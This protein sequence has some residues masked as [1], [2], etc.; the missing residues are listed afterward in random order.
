VKTPRFIRLLIPLLL[1]STPL[2]A[3]TF[4][5]SVASGDPGT[6]SVVLWTRVADPAAPPATD[7]PLTL[8]VA[9][10]PAMTTLVQTRTNL[11]ARA[12]NDFCIKVRVTG[13]NPRTRYWYRFTYGGTNRSPVGRT[14]TAALPTDPAP[15]RF[16]YLNCQ[17]YIGRHYN[18]LADLARREADTLDFVVH[19]GDYIYET[20][21]DP[22]FQTT[23]SPR[24]IVF[25]DLAGAKPLGTPTAPF[26]AA[27][28]LDN[29]RQL[30]RTYRSDPNLQRIHE[31]FPMIVIWDDHEFANDC[32][33]ANST[34]SDGREASELDLPRRRNAEQAWFE[35][36]P[37]G[38]ALSDTGTL[39]TAADLF[40]NT[41]IYRNFQ[42]GANL[43][44]FLTDYR[45]FRPDH[46]VPEDAFPGRIVIQ[47]FLMQSILTTNWPALRT[48]FDAYIDLRVPANAVTR[49]TLSNIVAGAVLASGVTGTRAT[50]YISN[51]I[52][53]DF[54]VNYANLLF[55]GAGLTNLTI[56]NVA[57]LPRGLSYLL[58]GKT[59]PFGS[60]GSRYL[61]PRDTYRLLAGFL[62]FFSPTIQNALGTNQLTFLAQSLAASQARWKIVGS[63][64]SFSPLGFNFADP[65]FP[66][67]DNFPRDFRIALQLNA[68]HWD[69]FP[70][71]RQAV[72]GLLATNRA[73]IISGDIHGS[74]I[75]R[76]LP[77]GGLVVPEFTG[78]SVSSES[79]RDVVETSVAGQPLLATIPNLDELVAA[80]DILVSDAVNKTGTAQMV[81]VNTQANGYVVV[82]A[83]TDRVLTEYRHVPS[84]L[85]STNL[86]APELGPVL[87]GLFTTSQYVVTR[88]GA[89]LGL[90]A[91]PNPNILTP[92][93]LT[94]GAIVVRWAASQG[95]GL[96]GTA[97]LGGAWAP[98]TN[99]ALSV[100]G[101]QVVAAVP[102]DSAARYFRVRCP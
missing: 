21:G 10:D 64:V 40:P 75:T 93:V 73:L 18:V 48:N 14:Q 11:L 55:A 36:I 58:L 78:T 65:P 69:G 71:F 63:S 57:A 86:T 102:V 27:R 54:S 95:C 2:L 23:N 41:R 42:F 25:D 94:N 49:L 3:N 9:S 80:T 19:L 81:D 61:L 100:V 24:S 97:T 56:T 53:G 66:L 52:A 91:V 72:L 6:N 30:Y 51:A 38:V 99:A 13:L 1:A 17:D 84:S 82:E 85:V 98:V 32:W 31:L 26:Y 101:N 60:I 33:G 92:V 96:E 67:P 29:Y 16:A 87:S 5:Q 28:S 89:T 50:S 34:D 35:F 45:T 62:G 15:V 76:H 4:P 70:D 39:F 47:E 90:R 59:T 44:L 37:T 83:S 12:T 8:E 22:S 74:F 7:R 68:D 20:T 46:L 77:G 43:G 79:F 88:D